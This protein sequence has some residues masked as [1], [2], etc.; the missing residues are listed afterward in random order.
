VSRSG[1]VLAPHR[2]RL[3][4]READGLLLAQVGPLLRLVEQPLQEVAAGGVLDDLVIGPVA[5]RCR[6][7]SRNDP[8]VEFDGARR[9]VAMATAYLGVHHLPWRPAA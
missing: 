7:R 4:D 2:V 5:S 6:A 9:A 8:L 3:L 1:V